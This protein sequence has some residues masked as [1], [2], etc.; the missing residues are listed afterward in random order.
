[1]TLTEAGKGAR[2]KIDLTA[3]HH[4]HLGKGDE[5]ERHGQ[6]PEGVPGRRRMRPA[7]SIDIARRRRIRLA[8]GMAFMIV[9]RGVAARF[10]VLSRF[11][12]RLSVLRQR[13][14]RRWCPRQ[15]PF[16]A[17]PG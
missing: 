15:C 4:E 10:P 2:A 14:M 12:A 13:T 11:F 3:A 9:G 16:R 1:M 17:V 5:H 6:V 8:N 7:G